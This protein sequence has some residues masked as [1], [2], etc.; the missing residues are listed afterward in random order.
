MTHRTALRNSVLCAIAVVAIAGC[1]APRIATNA[2][3]TASNAPASGGVTSIA[4]APASTPVPDTTGI[5]QQI[6]DINRAELMK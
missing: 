5:N 6:S 1:G 3:S 2:G 4:P